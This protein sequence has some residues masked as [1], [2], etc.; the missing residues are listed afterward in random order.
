MNHSKPF[1]NNDTCG[2][3]KLITTAR[4]PGAQVDFTAKLQKSL[5]GGDERTQAARNAIEDMS[6]NDEHNGQT[7]KHVAEKLCDVNSAPSCAQ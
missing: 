4:M 1:I 7:A 2:S 6:K 3:C 5:V